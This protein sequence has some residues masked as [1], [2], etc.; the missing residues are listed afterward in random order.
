MRIAICEDD[1]TQAK[2][3]D[4]YLRKM[5]GKYKIEEIVPYSSGESLYRAIG[6]KERFDFYLLDI[7]L[8]GLSGVELGMILRR[9][10]PEAG[11]VF[12]TDY[13][14]YV[15]QAFDLKS[16][17]YLL[18][19]VKSKV[20]L[21]TMSRLFE[22]HE[23]QYITYVLENERLLTLRIKD[24]ISVEFYYGEIIITTMSAVHK[25]HTNVKQEKARLTAMHFLKTHQGYYV[26]PDH[27]QKIC[28]DCIYCAKDIRIPVSTRQRKKLLE[29]FHQYFAKPQLPPVF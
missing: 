18:K 14:Q 7:N 9:T 25:F 27:V 15:T 23:K 21:R 19:P 12:I 24:I 16:A 28:S 4:F 2:I 20:F 8:P 10:D 5:A 13:P 26:N 29:E 1:V 3:L 11:L 17:Q 6:R 22:E